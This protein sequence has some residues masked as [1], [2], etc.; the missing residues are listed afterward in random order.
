MST[1]T[2]LKS[3]EVQLNVLPKPPDI[4]LAAMIPARPLLTLIRATNHLLLLRAWQCGG[5]ILPRYHD[6]L[7]VLSTGAMER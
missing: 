5:I 3:V 7:L 2:L 6:L 4:S 1:G